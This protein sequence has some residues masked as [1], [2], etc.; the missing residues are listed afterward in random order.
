[1]KANNWVSIL[2]L[3]GVICLCSNSAEAHWRGWK[4]LKKIALAPVHIAQA[5]IHVTTPIAMAPVTAPVTVPLHVANTRPVKV[6]AKDGWIVITAPVDLT[7]DLV[8][9]ADSASKTPGKANDLLDKSNQ[10]VGTITMTAS[11]AD[12]L[13]RDLDE[14]LAKLNEETITVGEWFKSFAGWAVS[15]CVAYTLWKMGR[16][17]WNL[18]VKKT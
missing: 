3:V 12:K 17:A 10:A 7:V 2:V 1:M 8:N 13:A 5:V 11:D 14:E 9:F 4:V 16:G 6:A 15:A 18:V